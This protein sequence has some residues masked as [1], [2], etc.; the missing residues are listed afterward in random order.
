MKST[1]YI[2]TVLTASLLAANVS[3]AQDYSANIFD[4]HD[5]VGSCNLRGDLHFMPPPRNTC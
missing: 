4:G 2:I 1:K 5:D 3:Q